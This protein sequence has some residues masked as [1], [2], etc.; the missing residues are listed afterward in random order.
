MW[1]H[2]KEKHK[3]DKIDD[4]L[5]KKMYINKENIKHKSVALQ[6]RTT[7]IYKIGVGALNSHPISSLTNYNDHYLLG[8]VKTH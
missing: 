5:K 8:N 7:D 6:G 2:N 4:L 1:Y 3:I